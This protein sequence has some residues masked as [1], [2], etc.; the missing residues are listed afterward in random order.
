MYWQSTD[1][2]RSSHMARFVT[3]YWIIAV[4]KASPLRIWKQTQCRSWNLIRYLVSI[5]SGWFN[6]NIRNN[7]Q[8]ALSIVVIIRTVRLSVWVLLGPMVDIFLVC[9]LTKVTNQDNELLTKCIINDNVLKYLLQYY[10]IF[11]SI[12]MLAQFEIMFTFF[13][14]NIPIPHI[15]RFQEV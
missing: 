7:C 11:K 3:L 10:K 12:H 2:Y 5:W 14:Q 1:Y 13:S 6:K 8:I 9:R 15:S 4:S